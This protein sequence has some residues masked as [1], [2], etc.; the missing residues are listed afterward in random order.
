MQL[1]ACCALFLAGKVEETPKK[2]KDIIK[3]AERILS[4]SEFAKFGE[5]PKVNF[6]FLHS[7]LLVYPLYITPLKSYHPFF[8]EELLILERILLQSIKF[9]LQVDH[10]YA[11]LLKYAKSLKSKLSCFSEET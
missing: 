2:A 7:E 8:Q 4:P 11:F 10:P 3:M 5:D 6:Y 9:D 1:T